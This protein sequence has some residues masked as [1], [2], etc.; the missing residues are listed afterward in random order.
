MKIDE[1]IGKYF[2][3]KGSKEEL[4]ILEAWKSESSENLVAI[5]KLETYWKNYEDIKDYKEYNKT[6]AWDTIS[7]QL[8]KPDSTESATTFSFPLWKAAASLII[9][10]GALF[11]IKTGAQEN[12]TAEKIVSTEEISEQSLDD[13]SIVWMNANSTAN[14]S[15]FSKTDRSIALTKGEAYFDVASDKT[16]PFV[17]T[18]GDFIVEVVG[19]EF[20]LKYDNAE[21]E[22]YVH[23]GRVLVTNGNRKVYLGAGDLLRGNSATFSKKENANSNTISWKTKTLEFNN[24]QL[25][26]VVQDLSDHYKLD[27]QLEKGLDHTDCFLNTAFSNE[28][29]EDVLSELEALFQINSHKVGNT[30]VIDKV[31]C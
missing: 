2:L 1:I 13:G 20:N 24:A 5:Q 22:I 28:K 3:G 19:T 17:V 18:A 29:I 25:S 8:D 26:D 12:I 27:I 31:N 4:E 21:V 11:F 23:E 7:S 14:F 16:H 6:S 10:L 15:S 30:I 9:L